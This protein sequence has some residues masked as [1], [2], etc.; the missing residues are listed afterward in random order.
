MENKEVSIDKK[1][2]VEQPRQVKRLTIFDLCDTLEDATNAILAVGG[3][4][5]TTSI[6]PTNDGKFVVESLCTCD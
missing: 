2:I 1:G 6:K 4:L 5:I 3:N